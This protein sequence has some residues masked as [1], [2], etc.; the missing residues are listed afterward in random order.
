M[1]VLNHATVASLFLLPAAPAWA[2]DPAAAAAQQHRE[3][4]ASQQQMLHND[5]RDFRDMSGGALAQAMADYRK[6]T[7][8]H[9]QNALQ[10]AALARDNSLPP[11]SGARIRDALE[12]D[13]TFWRNSLP[14][15]AR[16]WNAMNKQWLVP[17]SSLT[18]QQ[19]AQQ[20]AAW[21]SARDAWLDKRLQEAQLVRH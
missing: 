17:V 2:Q 20:R 14:V 9:R 21:F 4:V 1:R 8:P 3:Q 6:Q 5:A 12:S 15:N 7:E 13:L 16:D 11:G 19:W 10:V 18:D